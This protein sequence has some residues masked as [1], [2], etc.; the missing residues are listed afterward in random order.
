MELHAKKTKSMVISNRKDDVCKIKV[1][2]KELGQGKK[3]RYLGTMNDNRR[4]QVIILVEVKRKI[5]IAKV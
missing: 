1:K 4:W 2:G 5:S 3:F